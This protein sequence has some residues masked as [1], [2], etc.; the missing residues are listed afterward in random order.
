MFGG[1]GPMGRDFLASEVRKPQNTSVTL[2]RLGKR[3]IPWW[4]MVL[5]AV[6]LYCHLHMGAGNDS[7]IDRAIGGLLPVTN[8][9]KR[10][11][12]FPRDFQPGCHPPSQV[13]GLLKE[14][15]LQG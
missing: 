11:G 8:R 6:S 15:S 14:T 4:P 10:P 9:G 7:G 1:G 12:E 13:A 2:G 3:F 5:L